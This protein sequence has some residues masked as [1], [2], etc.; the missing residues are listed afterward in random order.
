MRLVLLVLVV[1]LLLFDSHGMPYYPIGALTNSW[2]HDLA[3]SKGCISF[4][5]YNGDAEDPRRLGR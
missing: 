3:H 2:K 5:I 4:N 1:V